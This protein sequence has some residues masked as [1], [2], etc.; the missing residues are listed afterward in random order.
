[1]VVLQHESYSWIDKSF[2]LNNVQFRIKIDS[3]FAF[4]LRGPV[5]KKVLTKI[6]S[7]AFVSV[8]ITNTK[9]HPK[10]AVVTS[11][12]VFYFSIPQQ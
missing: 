9:F 2:F 10:F 4:V 12:A 7:A 6:N 5:K 3:F 1:M 8:T 11:C